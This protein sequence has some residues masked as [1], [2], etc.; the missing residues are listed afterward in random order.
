MSER[1]ASDNQNK[2]AVIKDDNVLKQEKYLD[3]LAR[4]I[5]RDFFP[6]LYEYIDMDENRR[7]TYSYQ[8]LK[9]PSVHGSE[10]IDSSQ[11]IKHDNIDKSLSLNEFVETY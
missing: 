7:K 3:Q 1:L 8:D 5:R 10:D 11:A 4:I 6:Q 9:T 2:P